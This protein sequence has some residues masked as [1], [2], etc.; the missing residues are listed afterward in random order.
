M[1]Y[2]IGLK[3]QNVLFP[4]NTDDYISKNDPVRVYDAFVDTLDLKELG[5]EYIIKPG[6]P[7]YF[8]KTMLKL[9][10]YGPSYGIFSSRKLERATHHNLSFIWLMNN[11]KPDYRT[12]ARF[13]LKNAKAIKKILK[14]CVRLCIEMDLIEGNTLFID[15]SKFRANAGIGKTR[16]KES[17]EKELK[18]IDERIDQLVDEGTKID[19]QE[20]PESSHVQIK[21]EIR[22]N[23]DLAQCVK[24]HM[25]KLELSGKQN[26]NITDPD[27]VKAKN[28]QG[29]HSCHNVQVATDEKHGLIV[30]SE[31]ISQNNDLGQLSEQVEKAAENLGKKP[32]NVCAD[33]G[34][35]DSD[36]LVKIDKDI[37]VVVPSA[38]QTKEERSK[39]LKD[40]FDKDNFKYDKEHDEYT[41]PEGKLLKYKGRDNKEGTKFAYQARAK[42]CHQCKH[43]KKCTRS[44]KGRIIK[45]LLNEETKLKQEAIYKS[46]Y[47]QNIYKHRK[48][49]AELPFGHMKR[50]LKAGQFL[51]RGNK[52]VNAEASILATCF[53][54]VRMM[55][56]IGIPELILSLKTA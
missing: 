21:E 27:S 10:L 4:P 51:L 48:E 46:E 32:E 23:Q 53:N 30:S 41:C 52:N 7:E 54:I 20:E 14:Q 39:E 24:D 31:V 33:A 13:R 45:R 49:K 2:K 29:T 26:I 16:T 43:Y 37:I 50:N 55:T 25:K 22:N 35:F 19:E 34:Y 56:I 38:K 42:D 18:K 9:A 40:P 11:L 47:G 12:I 8:P 17:L 5:I 15:G 28:R 3:N 6:A 1:A 44:K 36:D